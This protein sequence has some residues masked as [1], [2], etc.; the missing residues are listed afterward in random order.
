[1]SAKP[2]PIVRVTRHIPF[3]AERVFD[4]WLD[5]KFAS[6]WLFTTWAGRIV[7]AEVDARVGGRFLFT[8]RRNGEDIEHTGEY[9]EIQRP[10][11]LVFTFGVPKYVPTFDRVSI[12]IVPKGDNACELTLTHEMTPES[13]DWASRTESGWSAI[14]EGLAANLGDNVAATNSAPAGLIGPLDVRMV[15]L[16]PGPIERAWEYLIDNEK[17]AKWFAG[18]LIEPRVGGK[19][20]LFFRHIQIAPEE[21]PPEEYRKY[22]DPG[23]TIEG[24]VTRFEPP[25]LLTFTWG[26]LDPAKGAEVSFE[27]T[28]QAITS[29]SSSR[30]TNSTTATKSSGSAR[31][32]TRTSPF[33]SPF[34]PA[35]SPCHSGGHMRASKRNMQAALRRRPPPASTP[36]RRCAS[37][38]VHRA[39][40]P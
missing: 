35:R 14:V 34:S 8:D 16:L 9:L 23:A 40:G 24:V 17:R 1:M 36:P 22:H 2:A 7:R 10:T 4:A 28:P 19:A 11:R 12:D 29:G 3:S 25:R 39:T 37:S 6:K 21:Q 30:I 33:S 18:G 26:E 32:G 31:A 13:R 27:L 38:E 20:A 5:P 15:R